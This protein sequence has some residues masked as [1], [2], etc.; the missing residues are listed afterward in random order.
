[1]E[2]IKFTNVPQARAAEQ[3]IKATAEVPQSIYDL[4]AETEAL[5]ELTGHLFERLQAVSASQPEAPSQVPG[6]QLFRSKV[7]AEISEHTCRIANINE[8]L[9]TVLRELEL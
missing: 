4:S 5:E 1:M 8:R 9:R 2:K 6:T 7:A 3:S